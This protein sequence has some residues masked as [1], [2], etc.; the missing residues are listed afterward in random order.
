MALKKQEGGLYG[1]VEVKL[2]RDDEATLHN[3]TE[4]L[5]WIA[6]Q[7]TSRDVALVFMAGHGMDEED[8]YYFLPS[9]VDLT[10]LR[11]TAEPESDIN[12]S[13][14]RIAGKALF[15]FDTCHSG[16][17]MGGRR[18]VA[19]DIN[20]MVNDLASAENGIVVFAASTGGNPPSNVKNGA[21]GPL[22]RHCSRR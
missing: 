9:D 5:D 2:L 13:L 21:T 11:R 17:V 1:V 10:R 20:G 8:R 16:A 3:V 15:F 7:V 4:G 19:P 18:G 14:K 12:D 6:E 22:P